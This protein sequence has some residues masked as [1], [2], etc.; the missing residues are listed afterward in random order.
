MDSIALQFIRED[1]CENRWR[2]SKMRIIE[3]IDLSGVKISPSW[4]L[5]WHGLWENEEPDPRCP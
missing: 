4:Q 5:K 3:K 1:E 2:A